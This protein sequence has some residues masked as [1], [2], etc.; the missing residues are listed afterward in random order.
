MV[1]GHGHCN[2]ELVNLELPVNSAYV[3][4]MDKTYG[5]IDAESMSM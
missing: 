5:N 2:F 4:S 3:P 1:I